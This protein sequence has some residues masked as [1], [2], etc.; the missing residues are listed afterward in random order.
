M[1]P[2]EVLCPHGGRDAGTWYGLFPGIWRM[3]WRAHL[4]HAVSGLFRF[5]VQFGDDADRG[6]CH[7]LPDSA[8]GRVSTDRCRSG[9]LFRVQK[10]ETVSLFPEIPGAC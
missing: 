5:P 8:G 1:E 4:V 9:D 3:G 10:K 2:S 6:A 7:L